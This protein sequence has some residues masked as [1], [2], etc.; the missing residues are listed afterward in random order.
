MYPDNIYMQLTQ[1]FS[2]NKNVKN[3]DL[4]K[5]FFKFHLI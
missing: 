3:H 1:Q 2:M 4:S 5:K